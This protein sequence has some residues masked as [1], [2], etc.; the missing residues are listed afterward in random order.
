[1]YRIRIPDEDFTF[2]CY[3]IEGRPVFNGPPNIMNA[4]TTVTTVGG[5][6]LRCIGP[7]DYRGLNTQE[8]V[9]VRA[10]E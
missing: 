1:M 8:L 10:G 4:G 5:R 6:V 7:G 2:C 3:D 9:A